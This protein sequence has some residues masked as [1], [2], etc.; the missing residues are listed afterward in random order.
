MDTTTGPLVAGRLTAMAADGRVRRCIGHGWQKTAHESSRRVNLLNLSR[1]KARS[2]QSCA[3]TP[4]RHQ[5]DQGLDFS[6]IRL[7]LS[8]DGDV[9]RERSSRASPSAGY[10]GSGS[11]PWRARGWHSVVIAAVAE[12]VRNTVQTYVVTKELKT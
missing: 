2:R 6:M 4:W 1:Y 3:I 12:Q 8:E 11:A 5:R 7:L 10:A 9:M